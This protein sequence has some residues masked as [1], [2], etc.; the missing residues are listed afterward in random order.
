MQDVLP[1]L[2]SNTEFANESIANF[3]IGKSYWKLNSPSKAIPYFQK[4]N[5]TFKEKTYIRPDL[6]EVFEL[7][8]KYYKKQKDLNSQLY[9][10]DQL[11]KADPY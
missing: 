3:Y 5:Q 9:Y 6:K 8:I 10:I 7:L 1:K 2:N 11:L 4:V